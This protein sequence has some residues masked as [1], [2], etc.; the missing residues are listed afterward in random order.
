MERAEELKSTVNV[1]LYLLEREDGKQLSAKNSP[2]GKTLTL[3]VTTRYYRKCFLL[4]AVGFRRIQV[5]DYQFS[6]TISH[7]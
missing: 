2:I 5:L 4:D 7:I 1:N 6:D 3:V